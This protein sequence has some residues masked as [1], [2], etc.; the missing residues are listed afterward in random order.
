[1]ANPPTKS[2]F[3]RACRGARKQQGGAAAWRGNDNP[4]LVLLRLV[5]VLQQR[6]SEYAGIEFDCFVV[7]PDDQCDVRNCLFHWQS[8][9]LG[10]NS[11]TEMAPEIFC[12]V[13]MRKLGN[14][15]GL[16]EEVA[17]RRPTLRY[18]KF[19]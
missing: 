2:R 7:V 12:V 5:L 13:H 3:L 18:V 17:Q 1:M 8:G 19:E 16:T 4:A 9:P 14:R 15:L 10:A 6:E 11:G